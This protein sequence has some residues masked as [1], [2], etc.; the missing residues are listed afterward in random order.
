MIRIFQDLKLKM[1][2]RSE[3]VYMEPATKIDYVEGAIDSKE[4]AKAIIVVE[5][6]KQNATAT[7]YIYV[8]MT[9]SSYGSYLR[10]KTYNTNTLFHA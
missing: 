3:A 6:I 8:L 7:R 2:C 9:P 1:H 5:T 10:M 4:A